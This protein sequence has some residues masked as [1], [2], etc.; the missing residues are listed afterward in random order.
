M[1]NLVKTDATLEASDIQIGAV[2]I[3]NA[4][5]DTRA[6]VSTAG[7]LHANIAQMAGATVATGNGTA[8]GSLRVSLPTDGTGVVGLIAGSAVIGGVTLPIASTLTTA[9]VSV[10]TTSG[11]VLIAALNT[12][13]KFLEITNTSTNANVYIGNTGLT[14]ST[15]HVISPGASF[16]IDTTICTAAIY[17]IVASSSITVTTMAW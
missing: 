15:G 3:K 17:G 16:T 11:G 14:T 12:S 1:A 7:A 6:V 8:A 2:E 4:S 9:Q 5:D 13:R 10:D